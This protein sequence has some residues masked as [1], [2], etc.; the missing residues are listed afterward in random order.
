MALSVSVLRFASP[1]L[2]CELYD[3][4]NTLGGKESSQ[5][6][7]R[8]FVDECLSRSQCQTL[9]EEG[10]VGHHLGW[11]LLVDGSNDSLESSVRV[12]SCCTCTLSHSDY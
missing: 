8:F 5:G 9:T 4:E 10:A 6:I 12:D 3:L 2:S 1:F 11:H 7:T